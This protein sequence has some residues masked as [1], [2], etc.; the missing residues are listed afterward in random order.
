MM[1][2][3]TLQPPTSSTTAQG[4]SWTQ[5]LLHTEV[6]WVNQEQESGLPYDIVLRNPETHAVLAY[7]EVKS[8]AWH[9][10]DAFEVSPAEMRW[11]QHH[12]PAYTVFRVS[13]ASTSNPSLV[14][15]TDPIA[16]WQAKAISL[17]LIA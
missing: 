4:E 11:A 17:C 1:V 12:G 14:R 16:L 5:M 2:R 7:V 9:S 15:L 13:G 10:K 8:S 6:V 3:G